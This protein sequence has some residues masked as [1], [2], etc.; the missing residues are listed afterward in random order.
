MAEFI[1]SSARIAQKELTE[2]FCG[3]FY[4][5]ELNFMNNIASHFMTIQN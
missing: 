5:S 4:H 2:Q 1:I 3:L